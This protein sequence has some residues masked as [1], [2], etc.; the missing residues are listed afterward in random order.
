MECLPPT[1]IT[2]GKLT[3]WIMWTIWKVRNELI[4]QK[5]ATSPEETLLRAIVVAR[6]WLNEQ[7]PV[8]HAPS[9]LIRALPTYER[10]LK[11]QSDA[12]W[13][14]E[15]SVAGLA[16]TIHNEEGPISFASHCLYVASPLIA[17]ALALREA[18]TMC[19]SLNRQRI[20]FE[21]DSRQ[22]IQAI[23]GG[24]IPPEIYGLVADILNLCSSFDAVYFSWIPRGKNFIS[25][26][27]AK[28]ALLS[29]IAV[30][31]HLDGA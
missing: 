18:V 4:F 13:R 7:I 3:P 15:T 9:K 22:L 2:T 14:T 1:G 26:S 21:S 17:E 31:N 25:D 16:W 19:G 11:V 29:A 24:I 23:T 10:C 27:V 6:E 28:S 8:A 30:M 5:K 20:H 12:A